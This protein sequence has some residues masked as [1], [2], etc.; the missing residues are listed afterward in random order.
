[1]DSTFAKAYTGLA[2]VYWDRYYFETYLKENFLDSCLLLANIALSFD[3]RLDEAYFLKGNYYYENAQNEEA[4]DNLD[5]ALKI[6]PNYYLAY[7]RKGYILLFVMNDY[8]KGLETYHKAIDLISGNERPFLLRDLAEP[9][10]CLGFFDKAKKYYQDAFMLDGDS[11]SYFH[12]LQYLEYAIGNFENAILFNEKTLKIDPNYIPCLECY[13]IAGLDQEAYN[14]AEKTVNQLKKSGNL[15]LIFSHRIGYAYWKAGKY[16]EAEPYFNDQIKFGLESIKL[17]RS[18]ASTVPQYYDLAATY[19]FLGDKNKAYQYLDE[20]NTL[21]FYP[22]WLIS[23]IKND[24][25][26]D[27][28]RNEERFQKILQNMEAKYQAEHERVRKWLEEKGKI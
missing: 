8:V 25:L 6:N 10:R 14:I 5:Q 21:N 16:K 15:P 24:P 22:S 4:M 3:D 13:S 17:G 12:E 7:S 1:M 18:Y 27:N 2:F 9:Y 19:A 28:I 26:F 23:L 20:F 11:V